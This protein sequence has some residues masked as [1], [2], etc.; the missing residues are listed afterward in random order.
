MSRAVVVNLEEGRAGPVTGVAGVGAVPAEPAGDGEPGV[1]RADARG[2][3]GGAAGDR[4]AVRRPDA[5]DESAAAERR[6]VDEV[7]RLRCARPRHAAAMSVRRGHQLLRGHGGGP[8]QRDRRRAVGGDLRAG[9]RT[10][11]QRDD[12]AGGHPVWASLYSAR[13]PDEG[14]VRAAADRDD[15]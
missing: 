11:R 3:G 9:R 10:R 1:P 12:A 14:G 4:A 5:V 6:S 15:R 8:D 2:D 13:H 7:V